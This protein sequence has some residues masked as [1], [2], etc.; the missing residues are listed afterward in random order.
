L[1]PRIAAAPDRAALGNAGGSFLSFALN[2]DVTEIESRQRWRRNDAAAG[3]S[4]R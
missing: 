2:V 1:F 4:V 3:V